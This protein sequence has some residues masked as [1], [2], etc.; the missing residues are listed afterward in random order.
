MRNQLLKG[1]ILT[2]IKNNLRDFNWEISIM[3]KDYLKKNIDGRSW[4][5]ITSID[6]LIEK[7]KKIV[8]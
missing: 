1:Q 2:R 3:K 5:K 7:R 6:L 8:S 4:N